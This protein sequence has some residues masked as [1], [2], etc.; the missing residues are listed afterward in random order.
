MMDL[1][2]TNSVAATFRDAAE[3][4]LGS[5]A[6]VDAIAL[7]DG[8]STT[9]PDNVW[10]EIA[11]SGWFRILLAEDKD[12]LGLGPVELG[13]VFWAVGRGLLRGPLLDHAVTLPL[14]VN[15]VG[16]PTSPTLARIL[17]GEAVFAFAE[18]L[19]GLH[20]DQA[21]AL[22]L[23][24]GKLNG[25]A[26]LVPFGQWADH[27]IVAAGGPA[28]PALVLVS[29]PAAQV[30]PLR[31]LDPCADLATVAFHDAPVGEDQ[32]LVQGDAVPALLAQIRDLKR[33]MVSA[34]M[35]GAVDEMVRMG[36]DYTKT[37]KQFGRPIG[38]FQAIQHMVAELAARSY[39]L[40]RLVVASLTDAAA[41]PARCAE[42]AVICKSYASLVGRYTA[43]EVLQVHGGIG[44]TKELPFHLYYRRALTNMGLLGEAD[45]LL[46]EIGRGAIAGPS[47]PSAGIS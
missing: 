1:P 33:L 43:E 21:D 20:A 10:T 13:A 38:S 16:G 9:F 40:N 37:R 45:D 15:A 42:L 4:L 18:P 14:I 22:I 24:D 12:G 41:S 44:F 6:T 27:V 47:V 25:E 19:T 34:E 5:F 7:S 36:L 46:T 29:Q 23:S 32:I 8:K 11:N 39:A 28:T 35:A 26:K 31:S 3:K 30:R 2:E 17:D